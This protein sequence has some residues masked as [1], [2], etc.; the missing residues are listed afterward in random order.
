[1]MMTIES[2][3]RKIKR[4]QHFMFVVYFLLNCIK[5]KY[6]RQYIYWRSSSF[7]RRDLSLSFCHSSFLSLSLSFSTQ[8]HT[9]IFCIYFCKSV[10]THKNFECRPKEEEEKWLKI[11]T[12]RTQFILILF[13]GDT[14]MQVTQQWKSN[15][16]NNYDERGVSLWESP[17]VNKLILSGWWQLSLI[18]KILKNNFCGLFL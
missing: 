5:E 14:S 9:F 7:V 2:M 18:K 8:N 10:Y 17:R 4:K 11:F 16:K 3:W 1:M 15:K 13:E 6:S 12:R